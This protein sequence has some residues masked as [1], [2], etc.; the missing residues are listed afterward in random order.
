MRH[1]ALL[2]AIV[3]G[4][5]VAEFAL[6]GQVP[7]PHS[8]ISPHG[9]HYTDTF[10]ADGTFSS[11]SD[12]LGGG[13]GPDCK[14]TDTGTWKLKKERNVVMACRTYNT[15]AVPEQCKPAQF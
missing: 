3:F 4:P 9:Q 12:C 8:S 5:T 7:L 6:P 13:N 11:V 2:L 14:I 10:K 15:W 1:R